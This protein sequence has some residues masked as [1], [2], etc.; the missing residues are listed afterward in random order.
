MPTVTRLP[1]GPAAPPNPANL[2]DLDL[3]MEGW[4][5]AL[6]A[7][8]KSVKTV[9]TYLEGVSRFSAF[10]REA[11]MPREVANIRR[12]HVETW[13]VEL[14]REFRPATV[15]NRYRSLQQFFK[16]SIEE[17]ELAESPMRNMR[18]PTVPIE[19]AAVLHDDDLRALLAACRGDD[20]DSVRD[21]ALLR[22]FV[23]TGARLAEVAT[24]TLGDVVI[25]RDARYV[26]V[27]GKGRKRR[28][29]PLDN[30]TARALNRYM[31]TR[32]R[33]AAATSEALWVG[34]RGPMTISGVQQVVRRRAQHAG[35]G[36]LNPHRLRHSFAHSFLKAGGEESDLMQLAGWSSRAMVVR[37]G[38]SMRE[39][40]AHAAH[41]RLG[42]GDRL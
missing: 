35:L 8:N 11:G 19:P 10:L 31:R 12:E 24:L 14:L 25:A 5:L 30:R 13:M 3:L 17:G 23:T 16:F 9:Q 28:R 18:A 1:A 26:S 40:R 6:T 29:L 27:L 4:E 21:L 32:L 15:S 33:H 42:I 34:H 20:F 36:K 38:S 22:V 39:E 7:Q 37:Y 2:D 41:Q